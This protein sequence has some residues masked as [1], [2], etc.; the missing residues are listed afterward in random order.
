MSH[1]KVSHSLF[2]SG[3][4]DGDVVTLRA[5]RQGGISD[6]MQITKEENNMS[7]WIENRLAQ[8]RLCKCQYNVEKIRCT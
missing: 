1:G 8:E 5:S 4:K 2:S 7:L 3:T 6:A